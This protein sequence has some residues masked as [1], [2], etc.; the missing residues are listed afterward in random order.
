VAFAR[1][2]ARRQTA[3]DADEGEVVLAIAANDLS[4][5]FTAL[6]REHRLVGP[7]DDVR[8]RDQIGAVVVTPGDEGSSEV[9]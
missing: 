6:A 3:F 5:P 8:G 7:G 1:G 2:A 9:R 4:F